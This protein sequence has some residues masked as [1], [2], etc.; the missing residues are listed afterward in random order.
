MRHLFTL[1]LGKT[2]N[3]EAV[4]SMAIL[5]LELFS[6]CHNGSFIPATETPVTAATRKRSL[7]KMKR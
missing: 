5:M 4:F 6:I 2:D 7:R 1:R 3:G